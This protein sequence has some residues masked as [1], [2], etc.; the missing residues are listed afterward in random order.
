MK[1]VHFDLAPIFRG[2][3]RQALL[4]HRDLRQAG[5]D[6]LL[7]VD[8]AGRLRRKAEADGIDGLVPLE[9]SR[10]RPDALG[11]L[12]TAPAVM[13]LLRRVRPDVVHFHEPA[14]LLYWPLAGRALKVETRRVSFPIKPMS[15]RLKYRPLDLHVGVS[16]EIADYLRSFGLRDV[17]TIRSGIDLARFEHPPHTRPLAGRHGFRLLYIGAFHKMKGVDLLLEA[18][19]RLAAASPA[20]ELH[21]VGDGDLLP[22]FRRDLE[23]RGLGDRAVFHGFREDTEVFLADADAVLIPSTHGEGSN[24]IVKEAMAAGK[25]PIASDLACNAELIEPGV[26]GL[27]FRNGDAADL[28]ERVL[29]LQRGDWTFDPQRL[30]GKAASFSDARMSAAYLALYREHLQTR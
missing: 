20:F 15:V 16:D 30:R 8:A 9:V 2:G 5:V 17:H 1:V 27:L 13:R 21:L 18:F 3:Q 14:S 19:A 26:D 29:Q 12:R 6:S 24:G 23:S 11:R 10:T 22:D 4:L 7:A 28:A 25:P